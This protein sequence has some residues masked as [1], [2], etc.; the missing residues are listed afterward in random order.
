RSFPEN[1]S[2]YV[3][4]SV[5]PRNFDGGEMVFGMFMF[6]EEFDTDLDVS[7]LVAE[8]IDFGAHELCA[9]LTDINNYNDTNLENNFAC[10]NFTIEPP[11]SQTKKRIKTFTAEEIYDL[12]KTIFWTAQLFPSANITGN[13]TVSL[14][15]RNSIDSV[16]LFEQKGL[17]LTEPLL[18]FG[19]YTI[20]DDKIEGIYKVRAR[21]IYSSKYFDSQDS[22]QFWLNGLADLGPANITI[23]KTPESVNFGGFGSVFVK[24]FSGNYNYDSLKFLVYGYPK[25]VLADTSGKGITA[26][27]HDSDVTVELSD[28]KRGETVY[29]ALPAFAKQNCDSNYDADIYRTRVRAYDSAGTPITTAD[30]DL[31]LL[32]SS[33]FCSS[34]SSPRQSSGKTT[35]LGLVRPQKTD[36]V[37]V[38]IADMPKEVSTSEDF[39]I[40]AKIKNNLNSSKQVE[41]YSYVYLSKNLVSEGGWTANKQAI[42]LDGSEEK[43]VELENRVK[44]GAALG[45]YDFKVRVKDGTKNYD[46][47]SEIKIVGQSA[48][49]KATAGA[50]APAITGSAVFISKASTLN[51]VLGLFVFLLLILVLALIKSK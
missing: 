37:L 3:G 33:S 24:F 38:E 10:A 17:G 25:Q 31:S 36:P 22:G 42:Y 34:S 47:D 12:N 32:G 5:F 11:A 4:V 18:L 48:S 27:S 14:Q 16:T 49:Q 13:L 35:A 44:A 50:G 8:E 1:A 19:N 26:S 43:T 2:T 30:A 21:F 9:E 46:A 45:R 39:T 7:D 6:G 15:K 29:I 41:V 40:R 23:L 20:P 51:P 28:I